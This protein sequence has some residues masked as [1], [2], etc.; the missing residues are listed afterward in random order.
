MKLRS[1]SINNDRFFDSPVSL[2]D[3]PQGKRKS[4]EEL[5]DQQFGQ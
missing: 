3:I 4:T 2:K 1:V 5:Y